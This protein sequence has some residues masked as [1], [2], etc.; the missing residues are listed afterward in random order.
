MQDVP[1]FFVLVE[2]K[3]VITIIENTV[4]AKAAMPPHGSVTA[5]S[6]G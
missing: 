5:A 6:G 3:I 2:M 4:N 1:N